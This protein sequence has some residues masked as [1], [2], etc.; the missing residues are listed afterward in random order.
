METASGSGGFNFVYL[1]IAKK[2]P[3][4]VCKEIQKYD[5]QVPEKMKVRLVN[6]PYE[7]H[8]VGFGHIGLQ[9]H[10]YYR[11][12]KAAK[13]RKCT[14]YRKW[15]PEREDGEFD[16]VK[17]RRLM[18]EEP[19]S[20]FGNETSMEALEQFEEFEANVLPALLKIDSDDKHFRNCELLQMEEDL[21]NGI[22]PTM[23]CVYVAVSDAVKYPKI[24]ATRKSHPSARLRDLSRHVP[25]PFHAVFWVPSMLPFKTEAAIH[26]H[27]DSF[28][29]KN[30]GACTEFFDVDIATVGEYLQANYHIQETDAI[31]IASNDV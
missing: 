29:I 3:Q 4:F 27:F 30:K 11:I 8:V 12:I 22:K 14:S 19:T 2:R 20:P 17:K 1:N 18:T 16:V 5:D 31:G 10:E 15:M 25:S 21:C 28:R 26:R 6:L 7:P 23:G 13:E 9:E 24:G